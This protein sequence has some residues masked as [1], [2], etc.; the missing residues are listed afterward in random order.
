MA[1]KCKS[2]TLETHC[3]C[4]R[5]FKSVYNRTNCS[6]NISEDK[7]GYREDSP[8]CVSRCYGCQ[9]VSRESSK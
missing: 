1:N 7:A 5:Y 4:V 3:K 8:K 6:L 2:C 9:N